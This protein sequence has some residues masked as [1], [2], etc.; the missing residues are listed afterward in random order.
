M[1]QQVCRGWAIAKSR[2]RVSETAPVPSVVSPRFLRLPDPDLARSKLSHRGRMSRRLCKILTFPLYQQLP[3][4]GAL[5]PHWVQD[6]EP[7]ICAQSPP[8][9]SL[10]QA[11]VL[12]PGLAD[13]LPTPSSPQVCDALGWRGGGGGIGLTSLANPFTLERP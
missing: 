2:T 12:P 8:V 1:I 4:L 9:P 6:P 10:L 11:S 13:L 5:G 3:V 7:H